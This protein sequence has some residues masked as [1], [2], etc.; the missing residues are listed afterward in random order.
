MKKVLMQSVLVAAVSLFALGCAPEPEKVCDSL[1]DIY[2]G[3]PDTPEW[4]K[5]D[6]SCIEAMEKR[7]KRKGV[8]SYRRYAECIFQADGIFDA[9]RCADAEEDPRD[10]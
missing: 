2:K 5:T 3:S 4:L 9:K 8:N 1:K 6:E 7:K 10:D